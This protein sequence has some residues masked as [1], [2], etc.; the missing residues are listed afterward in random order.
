[1]SHELRTPL[2]AIIGIA[3]ILDRQGNFNDKQKQLVSTLGIS[4]DALLSIINNSLDLSKIEAG[5][6]TLETRATDIRRE[7]G[8]VATM[9]TPRALEKHIALRTTTAPE[10]PEYFLS[11]SVRLR[12]VLVNLVGNAIKYTDAGQ[13]NVAVDCVSDKGGAWLTITIADTGIGMSEDQVA[14]IFNPYAQADETITRRFGGTGLGL[15]ITKKLVELMSGTIKVTS[16]AGQGSTFEVRLPLISHIATAHPP[17]V[18]VPTPRPAKASSIV[19]PS[20]RNILLVEDYEANVL[21]AR[22]L[23]ENLGYEIDIAKDGEAAVSAF[24]RGS[25]DLIL[26]DINLPR[27]D[28]Y[29]ATQAIR[30]IEADS[31]KVKTSGHGARIIG[32]TA[33]ALGDAAQKCFD[34][35]MDGYIAK[36]FSLDDFEQIVA[37]FAPESAG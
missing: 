29:E 7:Q 9:L 30:R 36:P 5:E 1:M 8:D 2:N 24:E 4:S 11:D 37:R 34:M 12:Q 19:M 13:V 33:H 6:L 27:L 14:R 17:R 21:V 16:T 25:Y 3:A 10:V 28:G 15:T 22:T 31:L 35:G 20:R 32:M 23:L 26:M 18:S